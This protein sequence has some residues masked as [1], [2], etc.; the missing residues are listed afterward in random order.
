MRHERPDQPARRV[1]YELLAAL[2]DRER[3]QV[4][5]ACAPRGFPRRAVVFH[6]GDPADALYLLSDGHVAI[7]VSTANGDGG[8]LAV[9][10]PG[11]MFGEQAL[12][13]PGGRRTASVVALEPVETLVLAGEAF[14][15]LRE[16]SRALDEFLIQLLSARVERLQ[17]HLIESL[18]VPVDQRVARRLLVLCRAYAGAEPGPVDVPLTQDDLAELSGATRPTVNQVLRRLQDDGVVA[19][20]RGRTAV[21]DVDRLR[22]HARGRPGRPPGDVSAGQQTRP[23]GGGSLSPVPPGGACS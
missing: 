4:L 15:A 19:L 11:R 3:E 9:L 21:L 7:R 6:E 18:Y 14:R 22:D 16:R 10:G 1:D 2:P 13:R 20:G 12:L 8:T 23:Q 5:A 17:Q